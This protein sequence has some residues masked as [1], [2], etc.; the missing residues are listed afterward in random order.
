[1]IPPGVRRH[2]SY[3]ADMSGGSPS[4]RNPWF[5]VGTLVFGLFLLFALS[6][7]LA[8]LGGIGAPELV[9]WLVLSVL[10][11][12]VW[13]IGR[14]RDPGVVDRVRVEHNPWFTVS[15]LLYGFLV[16]FTLLLVPA[17]FGGAFAIGSVEIL[18]WLALVAVWTVLWA[19]GRSRDPGSPERG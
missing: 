7:A 13:S 2:L 9:L 1:M 8:A 11:V 16:L 3:R 17:L 5:T 12:V 6:F 4:V 15:T 19:V 14:R 10:W 18:L